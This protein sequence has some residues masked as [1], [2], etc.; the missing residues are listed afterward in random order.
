VARAAATGLL[1]TLLPCGWLY[2]FGVTAAGTGSASGGMTV[3]LAFWAGNLPMLVAVG[4]GA[5]RLA[6]PLARRLPV[7]S[8]VFLVAL[9]LAT[10]AGKLRTDVS[11]PALLRDAPATITVPSA[12]AHGAHGAH[13]APAATAAPAAIDT[14]D[15]GSSHVGH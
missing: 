10:I 11:L 3:M 6:G 2:A 14:P 1:T 7:A 12:H 13:D 9:G 15:A 4:V 8:A 5:Q